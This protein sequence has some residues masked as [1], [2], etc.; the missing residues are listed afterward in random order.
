[1]PITANSVAHIRLTVTDIAYAC[2][3]ADLPTFSHAFKQTYQESPS[4][5]RRRV[6]SRRR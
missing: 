5:Y 3:F 6:G 4:T 1:M 2:G